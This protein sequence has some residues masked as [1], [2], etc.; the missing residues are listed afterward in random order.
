M[1]KKDIKLETSFEELNKIVSDADG[2]FDGKTPKEE[3]PKR[4]TDLLALLK[5]YWFDNPELKLGQIIDQIK[6]DEL[7]LG[8]LSDTEVIEYLR[9]ELDKKERFMY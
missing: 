3:H 1:D 6:P 9:K 2:V 8:E 4:I 5:I 7:L